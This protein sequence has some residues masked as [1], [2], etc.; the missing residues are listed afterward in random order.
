M[1]KENKNR[2]REKKRSTRKRNSVGAFII[3]GLLVL[4]AVTTA[5]VVLSGRVDTSGKPQPISRLPTRDFHSLA[6][7]P[8]D[9][10]TV[11]FGYH[12]GLLVSHDGGK[13]WQAT[14]LQNADAM[15]LAMS[16][17][18]PGIMYAAGH[19]VFYKS[20]DGGKTWQVMA[21]NLPGS[22]IHGFT[23]DPKNANKVYAHVVGFGVFG[24]QDGGLNWTQLSSG[25]PAS[26]FNLCVGVSSQTIYAA[27]GQAG[28][29][30][31]A[32]GGHT[33]ALV[34]NFPAGGAVAVAYS[35]AGKQLYVT[36]S[37]AA[38]G[39]YISGDNGKTRTASGLNGNLLAVAISPS[40]TGRLIAIDDQGHVYQSRD[41]G[42]TWPGN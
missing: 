14:T 32:D 39:L 25:A 10:D 28:L 11:F 24:S 17:S 27:A 6:F 20:V 41:N 23:V 37:G 33:W 29:W 22:G 5:W 12:D 3:G 31:S 9:P 13:G 15:A 30:S 8:S 40:D 7:S 34:E 21:T 4:I 1:T 36:T 35:A 38:A 19:D 18:N 42:L 16:P 26:I 2:F